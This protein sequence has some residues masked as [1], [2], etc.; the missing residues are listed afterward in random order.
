V[1]LAIV[2][3]PIR[4]RISILL[5]VAILCYSL[6]ASA[7]FGHS[8][9]YGLADTGYCTTNCDNP[10]HFDSIPLC[11]GF[12]IQLTL[13]IVVDNFNIETIHP[14]FSPELTN[15]ESQGSANYYFED[16]SRA[17]PAC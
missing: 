12:P 6:L 16:K 2:S 11:K 1:Y 17:P 13:G 14:V 10:E 8:H 15:N 9:F 4:K 7:H 3:Y 5:S